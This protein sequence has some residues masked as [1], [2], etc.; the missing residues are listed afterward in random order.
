M[1]GEKTTTLKSQQRFRSELHN[2][3]TE[4]VNK[5]ALN[6]NDDKNSRWSHLISIRHR[7]VVQLLELMKYPP[8]K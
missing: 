6:A 5:I 8:K 1:F 2:V 3:L 4:K 7:D